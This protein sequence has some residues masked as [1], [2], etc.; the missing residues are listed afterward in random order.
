M[1]SLVAVTGKTAAMP[2]REYVNLQFLRENLKTATL[3]RDERRRIDWQQIER[4]IDKFSQE[5]NA[6]AKAAAQVA[7]VSVSVCFGC[8]QRRVRCMSK[9]WLGYVWRLGQGASRADY[10]EMVCQGQ[11]AAPQNTSLVEATG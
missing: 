8:T 1:L 5:A 10:W 6:D 2:I 11:P 7:N 9:C 3:K 4:L